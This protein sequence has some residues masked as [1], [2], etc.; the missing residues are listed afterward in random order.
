MGEEAVDPGRL[1]SGRA[2]DAEARAYALDGARSA[3]IEF[4]VGCFLRIASPKINVG[5]VPDFEI[6]LRNFVEAVAFNEMAGEILDELLPLVPVFGRRDVLFVPER[7]KSVG[8]R[9]ELFGHEAE[10]DERADVILEQ[11]VVDLVD[12]G[13][14]VHGM[15]VFVFVIEAGFVVENRVKANVLEA[16]D[17]PGFAE[18]VA[19]AFAEGKDGATGAE[20]FFPEVGEGMGRSGG[21]YFDGLSKRL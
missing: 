1:G 8:I 4:V 17:A 11:A 9:S 15:A 10:L 6:P 12:V 19:V 13:V 2:T 14:V 7:M 3:V 18:I 16:G 5:F 21:V 20:H